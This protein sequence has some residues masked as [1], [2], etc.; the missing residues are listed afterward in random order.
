MEERCALCDCSLHHES[1][2]SGVPRWSEATESYFV[3]ERFFGRSSTRPGT[4][5]DPVFIKCPWGMERQTVLMCYECSEV[6]LHN[7]VILPGDVRR[8]AEL[9]ALRGLSEVVK[10]PDRSRLIGRV[11]LLQEV[12]A[13]GIKAVLESERS[14]QR[15]G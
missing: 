7:P 10:T 9:V 3:A 1:G 4:I 14:K 11:K 5:K 13:A 2:T 6:M 8:F 12:I 15:P